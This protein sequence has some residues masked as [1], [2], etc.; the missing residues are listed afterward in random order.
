MELGPCSNRIYLM[1]FP[2]CK[3]QSSAEDFVK[4]LLALAV[5]GNYTKIFAKVPSKFSA[6]FL[7]N[8]FS[9]EA[10]IPSYYKNGQDCIFLACYLDKK[11]ARETKAKT[12]DKILALAKAKRRGKLKPLEKIFC[13]AHCQNK[14]A[15][16]LAALYR[17]VFDTYPFP[18]FNPKYLQKTMRTHIDYFCVKTT[19]ANPVDE[20]YAAAASCEKD[21]ANKAV[22]M[23]DFATLSSY[24]R[25]GLAARLLRYMETQ[26]RKQNMKTA[27][28]IARAASAGANIIFAKAGYIFCGRLKNNTNISGG[29]ESMNV[30]YKKLR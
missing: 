13:L 10:K 5:K 6:V 18:I 24:L 3:G 14:D 1:K 16:E 29:I 8:G 26:M 25:R 9:Q 17:K 4:K 22:E 21:I 19:G 20:V 30:W 7:K 23:T 12:Y 11:R 15:K 27:F 2:R 28:T